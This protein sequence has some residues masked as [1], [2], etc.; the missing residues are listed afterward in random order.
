MRRFLKQQQIKSID[1]PN[2][3]Q[4][5]HQLLSKMTSVSNSGSLE[6]LPISLASYSQLMNLK[7]I[8]LSSFP[9]FQC[10]PELG[11]KLLPPITEYVLSLDQV[12][13]IGK[14]F[15]ELYPGL[16]LSP[17]LHL[18]RR[19]ARACIAG[20]VLGSRMCR[21]DRSS[22]I[23]ARWPSLSQSLSECELLTIGIVN[24]FIEYTVVTSDRINI[25]Y[26]F[27]YVS[28]F[29]PCPQRE[30]FGSSAVVSY[31]TTQCQSQYS[32]IPV[33]RISNRCTHG[34]I[35]VNFLTHHDRVFVAVPMDHKCCF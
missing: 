2:F 18:C 3:S 17:L 29:S 14:L 8:P 15:S 34:T 32:F 28:W 24:Y 9:N 4:E 21:S 23:A 26:I 6:T 11:M 27:A 20:E 12:G 1:L 10:M 33:Q 5:I 30:F 13:R 19:S 7:N 16:T 25:K 31:L 22:C 35:N